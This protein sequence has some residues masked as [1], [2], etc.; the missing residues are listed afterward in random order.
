MQDHFAKASIPGEAKVV[1]FVPTGLLVKQ[2][3]S[4]VKTYLSLLSAIEIRGNV[5]VITIQYN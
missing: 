4:M 1:F 2:Q 5:E 3:C